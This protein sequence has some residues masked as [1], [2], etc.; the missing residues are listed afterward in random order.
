MNIKKT[1]FI[2]MA[3]LAFSLSA[4][5]GSDGEG[6]LTAAVVDINVFALSIFY[7]KIYVYIGR[8][9]L[10]ELPYNVFPVF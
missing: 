3:A 7:G 9:L 2:I 5:G 8:I 6:N 10:A 1:P 4:C